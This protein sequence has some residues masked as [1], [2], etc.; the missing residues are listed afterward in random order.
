MNPRQV[1]WLIVAGLA[2]CVMFLFNLL[3]V[4]PAR[5]VAGN[6]RQATTNTPTHTPTPTPTTLTYHS[7]TFDGSVNTAQEWNGS[8]EK[9]GAVAGVQ[10]YIT[11]DDTYL[12]V[13]MLGGSTGTNSYNL[14]IDTDPARSGVANSGTQDEFCGA[15][16]GANAKPNYAIQKVGGSLQPKRLRAATLTITPT[17]TSCGFDNCRLL[18]SYSQQAF[19][20]TPEVGALYVEQN[21]SLW[22]VPAIWVTWTPLSGQTSTRSTTNQVEFRVQG[23]D[24]GLTDRNQPLGLYLYTCDASNHVL[25]VWPPSNLQSTSNV[26]ELSSRTYFSSTDSGRAPRDYAQ[27]WGEQTVLTPTGN[28]S[29]LNGFAQFNITAGGTGCTLSV[30]VR[31]NA[32]A[33]R[34]N[35]AVR[36]LYDIT[37]VNC[38]GL[39][40]DLTL[41]Y[42]DGSEYDAISE[43]NG[44][45]ETNLHLFHWNGSSWVDETGIVNPISNTVT[46][47]GVTSF[48]PWTFDDGAGPTAITLA[49][50]DVQSHTMGPTMFVLL[51]SVVLIGAG[52]AIWKRRRI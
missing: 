36:R 43:L 17:P 32:A 39:T 26:Q 14:L 50:L 33:D 49:R 15:T 29:L 19:T 2:L 27:Q 42:L 16:F 41:K 9:L 7:I 28:L 52:V 46:R 48:S 20:P 23:S 4:S 35:S 34:D 3:S 25:S 12:Y 5:V 6:L 10:Y 1:K 11:W 22:P 38:P 13:G 51:G 8:I 40:A 47:N 30:R 31:G 21:L 44:A 37:P 45:P 18:R 24:I